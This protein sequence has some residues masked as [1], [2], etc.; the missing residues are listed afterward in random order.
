M[1]SS[2]ESFVKLLIFLRVRFDFFFH[3][4]DTRSY[5]LLPRKIQDSLGIQMSFQQGV[6]RTYRAVLLL[7]ALSGSVR[8]VEGHEDECIKVL[9][10]AGQ[11]IFCSEKSEGKSTSLLTEIRG[12]L[13]AAGERQVSNHSSLLRVNARSLEST[14][15]K[16]LPLK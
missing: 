3:V 8:T 1:F 2:G 11:G 15:T 7:I 12:F 14:E 6:G 4:R 9:L 5:P 16:R 13:A 10:Q